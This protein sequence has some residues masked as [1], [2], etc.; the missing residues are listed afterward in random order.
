MTVKALLYVTRKP[1]TTPAEFQAYYDTVHLPLIKSL[2]G[3]DFPLSHKRLYLA[4]PTAGD[5]NT[6]PVTALLG[7]QEDFPYD[8]ITELTFPTEKAL[9]KFFKRRMEPGTKEAVDADEQ[10]FM[11]SSKLKLVLVGSVTETT[12]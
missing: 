2:A 8:C 6:Y 11:D 9:N 10:E 5:D 4:R 3:D 12:C 7:S 1:G